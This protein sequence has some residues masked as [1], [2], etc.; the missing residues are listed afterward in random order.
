MKLY[1]ISTNEYDYDEFISHVIAE[2]SVEEAKELAHLSGS[3][4]KW[5]SKEIGTYNKEVPG[6]VH[7]SFKAR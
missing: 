5:C 4:S 2:N 6:I 7:S 1:I 3:K